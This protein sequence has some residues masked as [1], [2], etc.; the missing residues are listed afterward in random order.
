MD[1][2]V[3]HASVLS[4]SM[5]TVSIETTDVGEL[6]DLKNGYTLVELMLCQFEAGLLAGMNTHRR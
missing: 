5:R 2:V 4:A 1:R 3:S 6:C